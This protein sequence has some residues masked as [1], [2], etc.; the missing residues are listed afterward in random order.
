[1]STFLE[2]FLDPSLPAEVLAYRQRWISGAGGIAEDLQSLVDDAIEMSR[3]LS[4]KGAGQPTLRVVPDAEDSYQAGGV[5][6]L[7]KGA[8]R[9]DFYEELLH[10][11]VFR[12]QNY[13]AASRIRCRLLLKTNGI[14]SRIGK[15]GEEMAVK[16][17][18][19]ANRRSFG[20]HQDDVDFL[21]AQIV[22][23][24][25]NGISDVY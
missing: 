6:F 5:I 7:R 22:W 23:I 19:V 24:S 8:R 13:L 10:F 14:K 11:R 9:L 21:Q 20:L 4:S 12:D 17:H 18:L 15:A 16:Q 25:R 3:R 1:M 2:V